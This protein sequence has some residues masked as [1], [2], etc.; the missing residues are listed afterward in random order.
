M[1]IF[2]D[3]ERE[4]PPGWFRTYTVDETLAL[5]QC[6]SVEE[7]SLDNDLGEGQPEGY[8]IVDWIE[9]Q[10]FR[11]PSFVPPKIRVHSANPVRSSYMKKIS[12]RVE[13]I[14]RQREKNL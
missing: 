4:T 7:I 11:D 9:E 5:L 13:E 2:L 6:N 10:V 3:D 1:K 12:L 14:L 8:K